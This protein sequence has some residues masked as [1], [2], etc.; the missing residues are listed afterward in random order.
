M[1][2]HLSIV[3]QRGQITLP[4]DIREKEG[5]KHKDK[6]I[7]KIEDNK[8]VVEKTRTQ[9]DRK[10][11]MIEGYRHLATLDQTT[12]GDFAYASAEADGM[13]DDY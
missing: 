2:E 5:I 3:G 6:V 9:K 4:K 7:V 10:A 1:Y 13:M 8:I 12:E 11:E